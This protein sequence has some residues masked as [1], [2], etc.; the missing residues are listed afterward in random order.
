MEDV[1]AD[2][3]NDGEIYGYVHRRTGESAKI[4]RKTKRECT[5]E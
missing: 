2:D 5:R 1:H 3:P 4:G